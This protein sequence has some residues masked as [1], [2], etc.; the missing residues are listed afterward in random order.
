VGFW[1]FGTTKNMRGWTPSR[2]IIRAAA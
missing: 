1:K 2:R